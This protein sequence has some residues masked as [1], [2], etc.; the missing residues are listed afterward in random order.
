[1]RP[2]QP[3]PPKLAAA[4]FLAKLRELT[5]GD[6]DAPGH[7]DAVIKRERTIAALA[8]AFS[9]LPPKMQRK[10]N[11][12]LTGSSLTDTLVYAEADDGSQS[13]EGVIVDG[14][15]DEEGQWELDAVHDLHHRP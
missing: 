9:C 3:W 8:A 11:L 4:L 5:R 6:R 2:W 12:R 10:C 1:M 14:Q 15:R 7:L 13:V